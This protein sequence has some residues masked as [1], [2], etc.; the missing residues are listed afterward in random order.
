MNLFLLGASHHSTPIDLRER[1]DFTRQD[2]A[3]ALADL[4]QLPGLSEVVVLSTCNRSEI[5]AIC[6]DAQRMRR[7]L[8]AFMSA[9]HDIPESEIAPHLYARTDTDV[10]RH[11]FR[12][13]AGLDSL[14]V[15][16]PQ[17]LGQ[18]KDAFTIASEQHHTGVFFNRLF[19]WSFG[20]GKRVRSETGLGEGAVSVGYASISLARKIFGKL[21][22]LRALL[23][24]AGE[25]AELTA[26]H[27]RSQQVHRIAVANRTASHAAAL[28]AR[29]GGEAVPWEQIGR[30]LTSYD[31][32]VTATGSTAPIITR[33]DVEIA[34]KPRRDRPLFVID[35][36]VP[37][38]VDP[39]AGRIEQV[40]LY[41][42]DD[43]R[44]IVQDNLA[45]RQSQVDLAEL[46]LE[47]EVERFMAWLRSRAAT[48][49]VVAL[50]ERF[51]AVRRSELAR[52]EPKLAGL[53][54]AARARVDEV[55]R[56]LVEKLLSA[57]TQ[58][59]KATA[60][61]ETVAAYTEVLNHLF[62]LAGDEDDTDAAA[63]SRVSDRMIASTRGRGR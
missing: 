45:R 56:L 54:P 35:L 10:A 7:T 34:M 39:A 12:V 14:V 53:P 15:G 8:T 47:A 50:R 23:V 60:D 57:P 42:I 13:A 44:T 43:L 38:D 36:G 51:E 63:S 16:E 6:D 29:V 20:A 1:I 22:N 11:L 21:D 28:A 62:E 26:T 27:L 49:T 46:M 55:T 5:Y 31:I 58:R 18:V 52:L 33:A 3:D 37:R 48:P 2:V 32:V 59:L 17:I 30:E 24:G 40:F 4:A 19:H 41:N 61:E 9:F 25:M